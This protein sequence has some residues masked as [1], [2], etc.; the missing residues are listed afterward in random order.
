VHG[1]AGRIANVHEF[2]RTLDE[3]ERVGAFEAPVRRAGLAEQK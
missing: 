1:I 3:R 2:T